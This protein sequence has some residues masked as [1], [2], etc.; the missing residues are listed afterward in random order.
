MLFFA[1]QIIFICFFCETKKITLRIFDKLKK[2]MNFLHNNKIKTISKKSS[3][4]IIF[5]NYYCTKKIL[6]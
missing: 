6:Q 5:F 4:L 2:I 1:S 3:V